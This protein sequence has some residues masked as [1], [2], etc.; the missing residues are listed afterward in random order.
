MTPWTAV[1]TALA[2]ALL[3]CHSSHAE[4]SAKDAAAVEAVA[5][6]AASYL[7]A[8]NLEG[9]AALF[10]DDVMF[11]PPNAPA[12]QGRSAVLAWAKKFPP[13]KDAAFTNVEIRGDGDLAYGTSGF[14]LVQQGVP[15][16]TG[17]QL[18]ISRRAGNGKWEVAVVSF[19]S[20]LPAAGGRTATR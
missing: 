8:G 19:N 6:S 16:D 9:W 20:D 12:I 10:S 3:G 18:W 13:I 4:F 5:D 7:R 11:H 15:A 14:R 1:V 2:L 17:K